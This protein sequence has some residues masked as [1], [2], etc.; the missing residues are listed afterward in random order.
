MQWT[1]TNKVNLAADGDNL[2]EL[3]SMVKA[4]VE[5]KVPF[6]LSIDISELTKPELLDAWPL[7]KSLLRQYA[8]VMA[9][10][11]HSLTVIGPKAIAA[12]APPGTGTVPDMVRYLRAC[13]ILCPLH[14][15]L[16]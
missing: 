16:R 10:T 6:D 2:D 13:G 14:C 1:T 9:L 15:E 5:L 11:T 4:C 8:G 7:I 3:D 12:S